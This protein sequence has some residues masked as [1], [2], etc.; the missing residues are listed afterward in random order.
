MHLNASLLHFY[1]QIFK[2]VKFFHLFILK[3]NYFYVD[4]YVSFLEGELWI[5]LFSWEASGRG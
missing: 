1:V 5:K 3:C 2:N 4:G